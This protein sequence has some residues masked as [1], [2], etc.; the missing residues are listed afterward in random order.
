MKKQIDIY[1]HPQLTEKNGTTASETVAIRSF[2][3]I[4]TTSTILLLKTGMALFN[5]YEAVLPIPGKG[6][7]VSDT[8]IIYHLFSNSAFFQ[9]PTSKCR[10]IY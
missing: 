9:Q 8:V 2:M 1:H 10:T 3:L 6:N 4:H 7:L 5:D